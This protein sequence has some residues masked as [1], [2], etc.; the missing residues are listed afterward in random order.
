MCLRKDCEKLFTVPSP[1]S[2]D[3]W[4]QSL[5]NYRVYLDSK[6][7]YIELHNKVNH[8][9]RLLASFNFTDFLMCYNLKLH[10]IIVALNFYFL[11]F[12][13]FPENTESST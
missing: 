12:V 10:T 6:H 11:D 4:K 13:I 1:E 8:E 9:I 2:T 5:N 3:F 7:T